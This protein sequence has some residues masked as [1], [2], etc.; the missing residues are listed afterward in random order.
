MA[1]DRRTMAE[2]HLQEGRR[3]FAR[4]REL[5]ARQRALGQDTTVSDALLVEFERS[6]IVF[7]Q[8][9]QSIQDHK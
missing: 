2:H 1:E 3:T 9:L 6:L 5:V 4:Q 7:E 8:D